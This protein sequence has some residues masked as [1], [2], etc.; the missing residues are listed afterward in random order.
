MAFA[1][2]GALNSPFVYCGVFPS[3]QVFKRLVEL[4]LAS[5][6]D[7]ERYRYMT[8]GFLHKYEDSHIR[9][10]RGSTKGQG[11]IWNPIL[12]SMILD[13]IQI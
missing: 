11:T 9:N 1:A 7:S 12:L 10:Y 4:S 2:E 6:K 8:H 3:V 5:N 13:D